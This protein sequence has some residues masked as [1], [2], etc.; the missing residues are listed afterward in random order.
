MS[1]IGQMQAGGIESVESREA[2]ASL[3]EKMTT[4]TTPTEQQR[5]DAEL[6]MRVPGNTFWGGIA[7]GLSGSGRL[8]QG[9]EGFLSNPGGPEAAIEFLRNQK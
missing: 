5:Q 3:L 1:V 6:F 2:L 8:S 7:R 9:A 4:G